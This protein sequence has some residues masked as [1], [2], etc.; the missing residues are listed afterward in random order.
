[1]TLTNELG[2]DARFGSLPKLAGSLNSLQLPKLVFLTTETT[3]RDREIG[4]LLMLRVPA[5]FCLV[6]LA[7]CAPP[8]QERRH[9]KVLHIPLRTS[10]PNSLDPVKGSSTYD[11][12]ASSYVYQTLLQYHYLRRPL[13]L[14]P[15]L[16]A[17]MPQVT[18]EGTLYRF[19]LRKDAYFHD[20]PCFPDGKG[21]QLVAADVFYSWK[22][23][24]NNKNLPKGWWLLKDTIVG[25][26]EYRDEQNAAERFDY[27]APVEGFKRIS[28]QEFE[29][30]LKQPF[31]RFTYTL[32]MFQTSIV[33]REAVEYYKK[34]F[35]RHPVGTGPF[36]LKHWEPN[37]RMTFVRNPN[38][39]EEYYPDDPGLQ[40]DGSEPYDGYL[41]DKALGFYADA[42][43][44]LPLADRV[45]L[46]MF[47]DFQP[48]WLKFRNHELDYVMVPFE[49]YTEAYIKRNQKLRKAFVDE[50]IRSEPVPLLDLIYHGFN[51]EDPDFGGYDDKQKW[52]RQAIS[53]AMDWDE[54]NEAF[55][56]GLTVVYDGPIPPG[57]DGHPPGHN[58]SNSY[59]GPDLPRARRLLA[60]AGYPG[61]KGLPKLVFYTSRG[62]KY[63]EMAEM[64]K[65]HLAKIGVKVDIRL[66]DFSTL[67]DAVRSKRAPFFGFAWGSDYPDAENNLQLFY[68]PFKS[69]SSNNFN[70]D[71]PE[72]NELYETIRVMPPSPERTK[73]YEKMRDMVIEDA[74]LLGSLARTRYYLIQGRL[75]NC[76][77]IETFH[78][79]NKYLNVQDN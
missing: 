40:A 5:L 17:E 4:T 28:D 14:E 76:K 62:A 39:R 23:M 59:R 60:K 46:G 79:W 38:Y 11:S 1:M 8:V 47:A 37:S 27:D 29:V 74:P 41:E 16:L 55:Y 69:P 68:G 52:L 25:F 71:R 15:L 19:K 78:N 35:S 49:N 7:G 45:E 9:E 61:G 53:L 24:A 70:Y 6:F 10:G 12:K 50:G 56:N 13:E 30:R 3:I 18:D 20:D 48:M 72:Y 66:N 77:P 33:P 75:Q 21:R 2:Y 34:K 58:L 65:R 43:K 54:R 67:M 22:R 31:Y 63:P 51:M 32:A 57:L 36:L 44:R 42:G 64:T 73:L 26:D